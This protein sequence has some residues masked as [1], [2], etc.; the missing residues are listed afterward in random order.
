MNVREIIKFKAK[1]S[2]INPYELYLGSISKD[3]SIDNMKK[4][5]LKGCVYDFD[6]DYDYIRVSD[7]L[8]THKYLT[9]KNKI[10]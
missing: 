8:D 9:E 7:I 2:E 5:G 6:T 10:V 1:H 3:W 4:T